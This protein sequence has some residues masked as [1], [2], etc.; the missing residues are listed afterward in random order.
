MLVV[1]ASWS[2]NAWTLNGRFYFINILKTRLLLKQW[3]YTRQKI[4]TECETLWPTNFLVARP[5]RCELKLSH[6][7]HNYSKLAFRRMRCQRTSIP[8][9][10][11][12]ITCQPEF[13]NI[14]PFVEKITTESICKAGFDRNMHDK[15]ISWLR[16]SQPGSEILRSLKGE[17]LVPLKILNFDQPVFSFEWPK[18]LQSPRLRQAGLLE[19]QQC[20]QESC[21]SFP[22]RW[23]A[24]RR[25]A[26]AWRWSRSPWMQRPC[27]SCGLSHRR[28]SP[29]TDND[30]SEQCCCW[31]VRQRTRQ[32]AFINKVGKK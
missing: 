18:Q 26:S 4:L 27:T 24:Q 13:K 23:S 11:T 21:C 12:A 7:F 8:K 28:S 31:P 3:K 5:R 20:T 29:W 9:T 22:V 32:K 1:K 15:N 30:K 25:L 14:P 10:L 6:N 17:L 19:Q 2:L 16:T